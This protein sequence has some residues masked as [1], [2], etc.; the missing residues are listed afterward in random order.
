MESQEI[1]SQYTERLEQFFLANSIANL[2]KASVLLATIGPVAF[3]ILGNLVSPKKPSEE[4]YENLIS[5]KSD[6]YNPK[7]LVT[8]QSYRFFS[9]FRHPDESI[10]TFVAKP[11]NLAKN[12]D[13][14]TALEDNLRDRLV[15]GGC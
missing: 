4:R 11:H 8:V 15:C 1:W 12:C 5:V 2:K 10:S 7:P 3:H 9:H 6:F 13:F 14:G